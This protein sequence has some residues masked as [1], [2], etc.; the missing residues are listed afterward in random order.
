MLDSSVQLYRQECP[1]ALEYLHDRYQY[2]HRE[3]DDRI[4]VPLIAVHYRNVAESAAAYRAAHCGVAED[5]RKGY[6][7]I[8][9]SDGTHS[10]IRTFA[11]I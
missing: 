2:D 5:R 10:G 4:I 3:H 7:Q 9:D 8:G 1:E 6:C 11:I